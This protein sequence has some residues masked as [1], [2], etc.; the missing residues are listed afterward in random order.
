ME[1][2][3]LMKSIKAL[4]AKISD[5]EGARN[6]LLQK[7]AKKVCPYSLG[8]TTTVKG[9][10]HAGKQCRIRS[11]SAKQIFN[12]NYSWR[13]TATVLKKNGEDSAHIAA[14]EEY[15]EKEYKRNQADNRSG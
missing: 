14:W 4:D 6:D 9:W 11:V 12:G 10:S 5:F 13:V 3:D 2:D 8:E 1:V 15:H 7:W